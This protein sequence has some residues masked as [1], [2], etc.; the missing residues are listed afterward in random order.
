MNSLEIEQLPEF[1]NHKLVTFLSD[2]KS[3]LRAFVAVH[4]DNLGPATGGTRMWVYPSE[5]DALRDALNLSRAMTYKCALAGL[6]YGGSKGVIMGDPERDKT[7]ELLRAYARSFNSLGGVTTGT[8]VG[9]NDDDVKVMRE[10]SEYILGA[11]DGN[12]LSTSITTA[13]GVFAAIKG[14]ARSIWG[15]EELWTKKFAIKGIGKAGFQ[16]M[17]LLDSEDADIVV[18]EIDRRKIKE[19]KRQFPRVRFVSPR[20]I[21]KQKVDIFC[22]CALGGDLNSEDVKELRCRAIVGAANNQ[23]VSSNIGDWLHN[24]GIVYV[25]DYVANAGGLITVVDELESDGYKKDRVVERINR[26]EG[27]VKNILTRSGRYNQSTN[28]V[29]DGM[30]EEIFKKKKPVKS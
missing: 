23:L 15:A 3:K 30:A 13:L 20:I 19:A 18:A 4:N 14:C 6:P 7:S 5:T 12:K 10:E 17:R 21:H 29:A 11:P 2:Q 28:R 24:N 26:I 25:P 16:L 9:L 22:P 1:D 27:T 8:D